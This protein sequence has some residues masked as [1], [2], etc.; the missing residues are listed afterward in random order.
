MEREP[1]GRTFLS[2]PRAA[3]EETPAGEPA[4]ARSLDSSAAL[5]KG[6]LELQAVYDAAPVMLCVVD[7]ERRILFGNRAF[8][9]FAE[10]NRGA[11]PGSRFGDLVG[12][13]RASAGPRGCGSGSRCHDCSLR[14]AVADTFRTGAPRSDVEYR[15]TLEV[16]GQL[17]EVVLLGSTALIDRTPPGR[18]VLCL[19]DITERVRGDEE[20]RASEERL[21]Q[22]VAARHQAEEALRRQEELYRTLVE[23]S[24]DAVVVVGLDG[25]LL[26]VNR[27][28]LGMFGVGSADETV[29]RSIF[30]FIAPEDR[31]TLLS[32]FAEVV[33]G[34][35]G[36]QTRYTAVRSD[37]TRFPIEASSSA[38]HGAS[39]RPV[40]LIAAVRDDSLRS[41]MEADLV[42]LKESAEA[43]SRA[44]S[45]FLANM[46]HEIRTPLNGVLGMLGLLLDTSMDA[47]QRRYAESARSS[48][49]A[50][51]S[52]VSDILD[53]SK[54]EAGKLAVDEVDFDVRRLLDELS[55][56][57]SPSAQQRRLAFHCSVDPGVPHRVR[58]DR[59]LLRQ[60]LVNLAGNAVKFTPSGEVEVR[61]EKVPFGG[62]GACLRFSVRDTGIG[63]P[64]EKI[65][66]LFQAFT[67]VDAST[68]RRYGGTGLGLAIC[69]Q[70]V[71]L[72]GGEIG[73][74]SRVGE[75]SEFWFAVPLKEPS[76][77][78]RSSW[79]SG[80]IGRVLPGRH[81]EGSRI[82][83]ADDNR[84][85]QEV[86]RSIL[87]R[88]GATVDLATNGVE[89]VEML[90][91]VRYDLVFMDV[92]MPEMDGLEAAATIRNPRSGVLDPEV[93]I[94][95]MT[96]HAMRED[97]EECLGAGMNDYVAKPID[98]ASLIAVLDRHLL[99]SK[100]ANAPPA[101]GPPA[102]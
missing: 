73:V 91:R 53:L 33:G 97:R 52:L 19:Q 64:G 14:L 36:L 43:A 99:G 77:D 38:I 47:T 96:A 8:R 78:G 102:S 46:S 22:D 95:A 28:G 44:K 24:P 41:K 40:G 13:I 65:G 60:V 34:R 100:D 76:G 74:T 57:I 93:P 21:R 82:L 18:M 59:R 3:G 98:P 62:K 6:D 58:G 48:G 2:S 49:D 68:T 89:A 39:G 66:S 50:L 81:Y 7:E 67:Q 32:R 26:F 16:A 54:I 55:R 69:R 23:T 80:P 85:N 101:G 45:A 51:L 31:E 9:S 71:G 25:R 56:T 11:R 4:P 35:P 5:P 63:I 17:R 61:L 15:T 37:G 88:L 20:L 84:V 94:V 12:C 75:G 42:L 72:M 79:S 10:A 92:Q 87:T 70:I 30:D 29:G 83:V 1:P 90:R 27:S 86:A